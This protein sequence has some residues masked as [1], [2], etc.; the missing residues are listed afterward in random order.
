MARVK[1]G[2]PFVTPVVVDKQVPITQ[3]CCNRVYI[4]V[5]KAGGNGI[6]TNIPAVG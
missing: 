1:K 5:D 3:K 6:V 4:L 2:N